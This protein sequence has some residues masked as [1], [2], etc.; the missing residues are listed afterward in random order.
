LSRLFDV[1]ADSGLV[2]TLAPLDREQ[3]RDYT[4][5]V[6]ARS[7][8]GAAY[9]DAVAAVNRPLLYHCAEFHQIGHTVAEISRRFFDFYVDAA[10]CRRPT[11]RR[12]PVIEAL[13]RLHV[14]VTDIRC[15]QVTLEPQLSLL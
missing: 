4:L 14:T 3:R 5:L 1:A 8:T 9:V 10:G 7:S 11:A 12:A 15:R 13:A 6:R 2:T